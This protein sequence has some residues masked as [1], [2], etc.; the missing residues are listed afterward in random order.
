M[1]CKSEMS[2]YH[3]SIHEQLKEKIIPCHQST[4]WAIFREASQM[5]LPKLLM[6]RN[7]LERISTA[8]IYHTP[9]ALKRSYCNLK[10]HASTE[11]Q[12]MEQYF[13]AREA[14]TKCYSSISWVDQH[15]K[16]LKF[17]P[18]RYSNCPSFGK[19]P[20]FV[21]QIKWEH[22]KILWFSLRPY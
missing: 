8:M 7:Q 17:S 2:K 11:E 20:A 21:S 4:V 16:S 15:W 18:Q 5:R 10:S 9:E 22:L 14:I 13:P 12:N 19:H 1:K 6:L 3:R